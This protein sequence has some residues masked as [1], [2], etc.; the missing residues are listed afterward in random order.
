MNGRVVVITASMW[1]LDLIHFVTDVGLEVFLERE[2]DVAY[3]LF[4]GEDL[5][6]P[7]LSLVIHIQDL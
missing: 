2:W 6:V 1:P 3:E 4:H 5:V 7:H